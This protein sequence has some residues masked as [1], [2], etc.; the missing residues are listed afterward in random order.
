M[1]Y[2]FYK[3]IHLLGIFTLFTALGGVL[4]SALYGGG[5]RNYSG[6]SWLMM[7]H[8]IAVLVIFVSGFGLIAK[9]QVGTPWP[10]WLWVKLLIWLVLATVTIGISRLPNLARFFWF[11]ILGCGGLAAYLAVTKP[12]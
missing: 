5:A 12:F 2:E 8:G 7:F 3:V 11:F 9:S 6:R 1:S 4:L 10:G